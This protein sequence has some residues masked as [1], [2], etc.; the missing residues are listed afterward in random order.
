MCIDIDCLADL[1]VNLGD[2]L[3]DD[4]L[5]ERI[6]VFRHDDERTGP[7]ITFCGNTRRGFRSDECARGLG[8]GQRRVAEDD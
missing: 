5:A 7:P 8:P 2:H 1:V 3:R 6:V 4:R